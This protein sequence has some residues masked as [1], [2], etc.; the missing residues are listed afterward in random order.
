MNKAITDG[1]QLMPPPFAKTI[2]A[3]SQG[4]GTPGSQTYETSGRIISD[5]PDFG[6]CLE[7]TK[8]KNIQ[9]LR[10]LG[11]TPVLPG[12]YLRVSARIKAVKGPLPT[13]RVAGFAGG[14]GGVQIKGI[15]IAGPA[16]AIAEGDG[17]V[18]VSAIVG[19]GAR[20]GVDMVWG[21][22]ALYGH[23][24][25]DFAGPN[26]GVLRIESIRIEDVTNIFLRDILSVVDVRDYGAVGDGE[27]DDTAAFETAIAA[28]QG[29]QLLVSRGQFLL[30]RHVTLPGPVHFEGTVT[31]PDDAALLIC[32]GFDLAHYADA[33]GNAELGLRKGI[34]ALMTADAPRAFD[35]CGRRVALYAP[36][37]PKTV[38]ELPVASSRRVLHNGVLVAQAS[39]AW[40]DERILSSATYDKDQPTS[41]T[42]VEN[43]SRISIGAL[44]ETEESDHEIFV[45][46][47]DTAAQQVTLSGRLP[48]ESGAHMITFRRSKYLLDFSKV[49]RLNDLTLSDVE[50]QC[51][52][53][54]NGVLLAAS[55]RNFQMKDCAIGEP[56]ERGLTSPG[57]GCSNLVL[58]RT[59]IVTRRGRGR[60]ITGFNVNADGARVQNCT[61]Y[62]AQP[63]GVF[64][65]SKVIVTGNRIAQPAGIAKSGTG[66]LLTRPDVS[67]VVQGNHFENCHVRQI[68]GDA[69][70]YASALAVS[71]NTVS[72]RGND[73]WTSS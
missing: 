20:I 71:G 58:D 10:Y 15:V 50:F 4:D 30:T 26:G 16:T 44:V 34:Q 41:L 25:L 68:P 28:A 32:R 19:A 69:V 21:R 64:H 38:A 22:E 14:Q 62:G 35:L 70:H 36:I 37:C 46:A 5:D 12:C 9:T 6:S 72:A 39:P 61:G 40:E 65:G 53:H 7:L 33:F 29:R 67:G 43:L 2:G 52:A 13:V 23:F 1:A 24:G 56:R 42:G 66:L 51:E 18:E 49:E 17:V 59:D 60:K 55:G 27:T 31:M 63:W 57:Q 73:D 47:R 8:T 11:E 3:F 54:A 45:G 48:L